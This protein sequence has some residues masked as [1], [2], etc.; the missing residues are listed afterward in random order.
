MY[1]GRIPESYLPSTPHKQ[2]KG[3]FHQ[4]VLKHHI[5]NGDSKDFSQ[6]PLLYHRVEEQNGL[7]LFVSRNLGTA[8]S[9]LQIFNVSEKKVRGKKGKKGFC[10]SLY[11]HHIPPYTYTP[12]KMRYRLLFIILHELQVPWG[13]REKKKGAVV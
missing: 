2:V 13:E 6:H 10:S 1:L 5:H 9:A 11:F 8:F 7:I 12:S 3:V 4:Q